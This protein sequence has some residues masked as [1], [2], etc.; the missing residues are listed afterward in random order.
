MTDRIP[1]YCDCCGD[2]LMAEWMPGG[3]ILIHCIRRGTK[4]HVI[5]EIDKM[6]YSSGEKTVSET[7]E[8]VMK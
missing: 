2:E 3:K 5:I 4:H 1:I 7:T 6:C 8:D